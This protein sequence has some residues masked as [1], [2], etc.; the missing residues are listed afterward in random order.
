[1]IAREIAEASGSVAVGYAMREG[2]DDLNEVIR[3]SDQKMYENKS[4]YYRQSGHDRR[5]R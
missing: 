3:E 5:R 4:A 2:R 1:M